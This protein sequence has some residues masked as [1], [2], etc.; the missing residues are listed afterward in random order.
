MP[1]EELFEPGEYLDQHGPGF[2]TVGTKPDGRWRQQSYELTLLPAVVK[3]A[4]PTVDTYI[5][6]AAFKTNNRLASNVLSVG[7]LFADLDTYN[8][9]GL[10]NKAP[11]DQAQALALYCRTEGVPVPSIVLFSGRGLQPKWLL[12]TALGSISLKEWSYVEEKLIK[13]L[14]PF[15]ADTNAKDISR[16]LRLDQTINTKSGEYC[17]IVYTSSGVDNVLA[18]YDFAEFYENMAGR[19]PEELPR[20]RQVK[21]GAKILQ[22]PAEMNL[23]RLNWHR[24]EDIRTL[25]RHRG[26]VPEGFRE[27][28]LFW[29]MNFLLRAEPG[30]EANIWKEA[31][32][33]AGEIDNHQG[34]YHRSDLSTVYRKAKELKSGGTVEYKGQSY[35]PLYTPRN[36][37][38]INRFRITPEEE[39]LLS[40]IISK[41]EKYRRK[42]QKRR[43]AGVLPK[44]E[45]YARDSIEKDRPW[46]RDGVSRAT[47]YR[48]REER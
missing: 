19:F 20:T 44:D 4:D 15:G 1:Q 33:L 42:V 13:I 5:T 32:M 26:G 8:C 2:F 21:P 16:V 23:Q 24:L 14:E 9:Q 38:L 43:E 29:E 39:K 40:T 34:W 6:Q 45:Y 10:I 41:G 35:P 7:V 27:V 31:Q 17:R 18:R 25:W 12:S 3:H 48:R 36:Q 11:E 30:R 22:L 28:T 37:T 47:W 46:E